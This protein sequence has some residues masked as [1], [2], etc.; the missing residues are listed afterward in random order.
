VKSP[1][2]NVTVI[3]VVGQKVE[4]KFGNAA[5]TPAVV[6]VT[7]PSS[8]GSST[9]P[10]NNGDPGQPNPPP[11]NDKLSKQTNLLSPP[12]NM[13]P[14]YIGLAVAGVGIV[15]AIVF[16]AFKADAQSKADK[17]AADIR[18]AAQSP[19][20]NIPV[21]GAC[22]S[23]DPRAA[24]LQNACKTLRDNNSKVDTNA[25]IANV[26]IGVAVAGA[27]FALGWYL[28]ASKK[29][30]SKTGTTDP[31]HR[32]VKTAKKPHAPELAPYAGWQSGGLSLTGEF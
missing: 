16:A 28:L 3:A 9:P 22:N 5:S 13:T 32:D 6:P 7:S 1:T 25:T 10:P 29:D 11:P 27:V 12:E 2:Q 24:D 26:S 8:S 15:S 30:D 14:V 17:V 31:H 23:S 18:A 4:A 20:R 19:Q 21:Q